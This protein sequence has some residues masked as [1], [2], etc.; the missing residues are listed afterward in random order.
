M[1]SSETTPC[2]RCVEVVAKAEECIRTHP[3]EAAVTS[4]CAGFLIAQLPLR[5]LAAA[6]ARL[7]LL[8]IKPAALL[9]G[10]YRLADDC[11]AKHHGEKANPDL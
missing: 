9:Y 11:Y 5:L 8:V 3:T 4:L 7:I 2:C 6:I 10:L 1:E